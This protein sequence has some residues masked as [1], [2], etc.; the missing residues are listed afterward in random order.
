MSERSIS[1]FDFNANDEEY[2]IIKDSLLAVGNR[3]DFKQV[4]TQRT[5][6]VF[7]DEIP[8][9][10]GISPEGLFTGSGVI[11]LRRMR[12]DKGNLR[13][14]RMMGTFLHE[15]GHAVDRYSIGK[16]KEQDIIRLF[17]PVPDN[18][19]ASPAGDQDYWKIPFESFCDWWC[20]MATDDQIISHYESR[21]LFMPLSKRPRLLPIILG[22]SEPPEP[23][24]ESPDP[25]NED[26]GEMAVILQNIQENQRGRVRS[27][28]AIYNPV[29]LQKM[30]RIPEN[31]A[32]R[33]VGKSA[34]GKYHGILVITRQLPGTNPKLAL[35]DAENVSNLRI[36]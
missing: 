14:Y 13:K 22:P 11:Q 27:D 21:R 18:W 30:F 29:T 7:L 31:P 8:R 36:V 3:V 2:R 15:T 10:G 24:E 16:K 35:V 17:S 19:R 1:V 33:I 28:S 32:S 4:I 9:M 12:D 34:D 26:E 23:V 25:I 20:R 6:V 5:K